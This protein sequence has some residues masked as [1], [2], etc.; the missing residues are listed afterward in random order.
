MHLRDEEASLAMDP[1]FGDSVDLIIST[2]GPTQCGVE[3]EQP[4][5]TPMEA[6]FPTY[7]ATKIEEL[8]VFT[9]TEEVVL[10]EDASD[11]EEDAARSGTMDCPTLSLVDATIEEPLSPR[12]QRTTITTGRKHK[13]FD[14][15]SLRQSARLAQRNTLRN[16]GIIGNDGKFDEDVIQGYA[17]YLKEALPQDLLSSLMHMKGRVFWDLVEKTSSSLR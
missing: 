3:K 10:V 16:L 12:L 9:P 8:Q 13:S 6:P 5:D 4:D 14:R 11:D 2:D 1:T 7:I 15:S 17:D